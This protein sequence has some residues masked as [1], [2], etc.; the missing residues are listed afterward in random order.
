MTM[1]TA[2]PEICPDCKVSNYIYLGDTTAANA[3]SV[4]CWQCK[5]KWIV[6]ESIRHATSNAFVGDGAPNP[7]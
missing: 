6:R 7:R 2:I 5:R 4:R 1:R 3:V